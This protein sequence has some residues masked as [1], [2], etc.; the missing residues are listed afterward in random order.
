MLV[1][2]PTFVFPKIGGGTI[3]KTLQEAYRPN[4]IAALEWNGFKS[5][6]EMYA[7]ENLLKTTIKRLDMSVNL[8]QMKAILDVV[9]IDGSEGIDLESPVLNMKIV[10]SAVQS[11]FDQQGRE[12]LAAS[13]SRVMLE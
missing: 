4:V 11:F 2:Q 8:E 13:V 7:T 6:E 12:H 3:T 10:G 9:L 5:Y 1:E